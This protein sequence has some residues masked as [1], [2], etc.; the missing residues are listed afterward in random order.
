MNS[1]TQSGA[2]FPSLNPGPSWNVPRVSLPGLFGMQSQFQQEWWYY[3]G[4][5][6]SI[7]GKAFSLQ[8]QILRATI[9]QPFQIGYGI[10]G[11][12]WKDED[13]SYYISGQGFGLGAAE[14]LLTLPSVLV[15]PVNDYAYSASMV[16]LLEITGRSSD[17]LNDIHLNFPFPKG[18]DGWKFEYLPNQSGRNP[19]GSIGSVYSISAHGIGYKTSANNGG[20]AESA[21][22]ISLTVED[23][24]GMVMEGV[25]GYVG[26]DMF[27][28]GGDAPASYECAQPFLNIQSGGSLEIDGETHVIEKGYLWLDRQMVV[29]EENSSSEK[30]AVPG[31]AEELKEF[32][33]QKAPSPKSL[34]LGDW[35]GFVLDNGVSI[36]LA[37]FWQKSVPQWITGTKTGHPPKRGFGNLYFKIDGDAPV[38]NGGMALRPKL[39]L[40]S[41]DWDYDVNIL[42]PGEPEKSPHW[43]S[44]LSGQTYATAWQIDF[45]H[46]LSGY[47]LPETM[48]V[49]AVSD[50]CE[51]VMLSKKGAF[52]EGAALAYADKERKKFLGHVFVEQ[53]GFN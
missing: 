23:K 43:Q 51:I 17:L 6:Y 25:S 14:T 33:L 16:P 26:P 27:P 47:G 5:V 1:D 29:T 22:R 11:I 44:P 12:G 39:E 7:S 13:E 40:G 45:A 49:F 38:A 8:I 10:T 41:D 37:E 15:P 20:T 21:Y 35:M 53:M 3:V 9:S 18:W 19:V 4:T 36:V 24:R 2:S 34:Y 32:L 28:N 31:N 46:G 48:Y 30:I 50:N 52:F 42:C